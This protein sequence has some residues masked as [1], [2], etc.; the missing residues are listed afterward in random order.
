MAKLMAC[1]CRPDWRRCLQ[2]EPTRWIGRPSRPKRTLPCP[3]PDAGGVPEARRG[4]GAGSRGGRGAWIGARARG[5]GGGN[6]IPLARDAQQQRNAPG[7]SV[8]LAGASVCPRLV[9]CEEGE[10]ASGQRRMLLEERVEVGRLQDHHDGRVRVGG[11][12]GSGQACLE[13]GGATPP[14][15][16][17]TGSAS[18]RLGSKRVGGQARRCGGK[19]SGAPVA[20]RRGGEWWWGSFEE[21]GGAGAK[22]A[23][24]CSSGSVRAPSPGKALRSAVPPRAQT[25][26]CG[27]AS[28]WPRPRIGPS[29]PRSTPCSSSRRGRRR[30]GWMTR[31]KQTRSSRPPDK[32][33]G[34]GQWEPGRGEDVEGD[35]GW[36]RPASAVGGASG[37]LRPR[38]TA[39][40][41]ACGVPTGPSPMPNSSRMGAK[42]GDGDR[43]RCPLREEGT[44]HPL[45][46]GMVCKC[47]ERGA[48]KEVPRKRCRERGGVKEVVPH[49]FVLPWR[50]G[51]SVQIEHRLLLQREGRGVAAARLH[52]YPR[53]LERLWQRDLV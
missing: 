49:L 8:G 2:L 32:G 33:E 11:D 10:E 31:R 24:Q 36:L 46:H 19:S 6:L 38:A 30:A 29:R 43:R 52:G 13:Q 3:S 40:G 51:A 44:L 17:Q 18:G 22:C 39:G 53:G 20:G 23:L 14:V 45:A 26:P 37:Q 42:G 5:E 7:R 12:G 1:P 25:R 50:R 34:E 9:L 27:T 16:C 4:G 48:V 15:S 21:R 28:A 41:A 47:R 35:D